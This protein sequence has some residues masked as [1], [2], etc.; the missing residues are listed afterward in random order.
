MIRKVER[1]AGEAC[2]LPAFSEPSFAVSENVDPVVC[3]GTVARGCI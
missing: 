1:S 2:L 3:G